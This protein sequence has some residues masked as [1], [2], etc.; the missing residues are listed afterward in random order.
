VTPSAGMDHNLY[1]W[2]PLPAR[3]PLTWPGGAA[4]ALCVVVSLEQVEWSPPE[5]VVPPSVRGAV[6]PRAFDPVVLSLHEYGNRVG[7]FRVLDVL[8]R[9]G[10]R[11][12]AAVDA[13]TCERRPRLVQECRARGFSFAGHGVSASRMTTESTPEG[14]EREAIGRCLAALERVAGSAPRGWLGVDY[15]ESSRTLRL[16]AEA[17]VRYVCDWPNDEQ[18]YRMTTEAGDLLSLPVAVDLDDAVAMR[19][20]SLPAPRW[21]ELVLA[22]AARLAEEGRGSGRLLVLNLHPYVV[23]QPFRIGQLE[24]ALRSLSEREDVWAATADEIV[25]W[26]LDFSARRS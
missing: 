6:Y 15:G 16:L 1:A 18:P 12:T 13:L 5:G 19:V 17:G 20:R 3:P 26:M 24:R 9:L 7:V 4:L 22:A 8:D 25:D 11:C 10:L 21:A 14:E 2:S 23:G